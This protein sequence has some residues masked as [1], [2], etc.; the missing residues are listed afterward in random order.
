M[1]NTIVHYSDLHLKLYKQHKRDKKILKQALKEWTDLKP[2]RIVFTG[3][4]V[5]SKNQM[6]PELINLMCWWMTETAKICKCIY[7]IGNH[8]FLENNIDRL[9]AITPVVNSLDNN[10]ITYYKNR[11]CYEDEN[12]LWCVYSLISHNVK[13]DIPEHTEKYKVGLFHGMIEG[14]SNDFGYTFND[15][16]SIDRFDGCDV[17]LAGDIH[18]RQTY[19]IPNNKKAYM[20]GSMICQNFGESINKHGY[21]VYNV[22]NNKYNYFEL[23]NPKPYLNF[24]ITDIEDIENEK[25]ILING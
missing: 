10:N 11:G 8:D 6:T 5:H 12:I 18:K 7:L 2:D 25:E 13:P 19:K 22:K 16:Y 4:L 1:I 14:S 3:D 15:G 23:D 17:V 20:I 24:R 21:G 9:D